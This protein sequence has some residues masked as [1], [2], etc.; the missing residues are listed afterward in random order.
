LPSLPAAARQQTQICALSIRLTPPFR[1]RSANQSGFV[2]PEAAVLEAAV[3]EVGAPEV[4]APE[5]AA[6]EV[7]VLEAVVP[8]AVAPEVVAPEVV[9]PEAV[10]PEAVVPEAVVPEAVVPEAVVPEVVA[11]E[12]VVPVA[13]APEAVVPVV[14]VL[15]EVVLLELEVV[16]LE[17]AAA[18]APV[19]PEG[20]AQAEALVLAL[21]EARRV[22]VGRPALAIWVV[23]LVAAS[24][25]AQA[26]AVLE[27]PHPTGRQTAAGTRGA[28]TGAERRRKELGPIP[29]ARSTSTAI[30]TGP[31]P[32]A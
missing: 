14:V 12:A 27:Q 22:R 18:V 32:I 8:E 24:Q 25:R 29:C 16:L 30:A 5:A 15:L 17:V 19:A 4:V 9:A 26:R 6:P 28:T 20:V 11:P 2:R 31:R 23:P 1:G 10:V 7:A 3:L 13:V 21:L